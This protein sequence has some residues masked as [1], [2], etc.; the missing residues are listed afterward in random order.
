MK[1]KLYNLI[2]KS[3]TVPTKFMLG[4]TS[5]IWS[6]T[7]YQMHH[8]LSI[9]FILI[10]LYGISMFWRIVDNSHRAIIAPFFAGMGAILWSYEAWVNILREETISSHIILPCV[11]AVAA[12]W[13][14]LRCGSGEVLGRHC[15]KSRCPLDTITIKG[16]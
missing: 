12:L 14:L 15:Y 9:F 1:T 10:F 4:M 5:I 2:F 7:E 11:F 8:K 13:L 6:I 3:H 16:K